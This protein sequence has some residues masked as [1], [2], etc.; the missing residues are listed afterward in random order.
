[1]HLNGI[2]LLNDGLVIYSY[3]AVKSCTIF[4]I[5]GVLWLDS[6]EEFQLCGKLLPVCDCVW[7]GGVP[8]L[9]K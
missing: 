4:G 5:V 9:T 8:Q 7:L 2:F 6:V 1:M 3:F